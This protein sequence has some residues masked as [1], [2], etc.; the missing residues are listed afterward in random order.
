MICC[1]RTGCIPAVWQALPVVAPGVTS[2]GH[3]DGW[4]PHALRQHS[5]SALKVP[6]WELPTRGLAFV[7]FLTGVTSRQHRRERADDARHHALLAFGGRRT[8][9]GSAMD[10]ARDPDA[11]ADGDNEQYKQPKHFHRGGAWRKQREAEE[12]AALQGV[13]IA[14]GPAP[15]FAP[16]A[17][18][19]D[20]N[21]KQRSKRR[22]RGQSGLLDKNVLERARAAAEEGWDEGRWERLGQGEWSEDLSEE[23]LPH[24]VRTR[25]KGIETPKAIRE[26][27]DTN[28][29]GKRTMNR[30]PKAE[31]RKVIFSGS[32]PAH[33]GTRYS[34]DDGTG[35]VLGRMAIAVH[36]GFLRQ[37]ASCYPRGMRDQLGQF[38]LAE[39]PEVAFIGASNVGKSSLLNAITR[40]MKLAEARDEAGVTRSMDWYK[41]SRLPIDIIDLPGYG[42]AKGADFGG[43]VA[44]FVGGRK[45]LRTIY[46]LVDARCGL[47]LGDWNWLDML[48]DQGPEKVFILTKC[49]LVVPKTLGKMATA[50]L[51]DIRCVPRASDRLLMVSSRCGHGMHELR[52]E[53][54]ARAVHWAEKAKKHTERRAKLTVPSDAQEAQ[55]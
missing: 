33:N 22:L 20:G 32:D 3:P 31:R 42:L 48:G 14:A 46:V 25:I 4:A 54:C 34:I 51:Q 28:Q 11:G 27:I 7:A 50:V 21:R 41:C 40:T 38:P 55:S 2:V 18:I 45:A 35:S 47:R 44:D 53:L 24:K 30:L 10:D 5:S 13:E 37:R 36:K 19:A 8:K 12:L 49:D 16:A 6:P 52:Y 9:P 29:L 43:L 39:R 26:H 1:P 15:V 17:A 23:L